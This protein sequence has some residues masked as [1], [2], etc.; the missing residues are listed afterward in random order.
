MRLETPWRFTE[1]PYNLFN[2]D[3]NQDGRSGRDVAHVR[4]ACAEDAPTRGSVRL[5]R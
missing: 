1:T 3:R 5:Y 4:A 2:V